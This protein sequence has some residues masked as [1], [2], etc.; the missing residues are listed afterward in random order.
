MSTNHF[1]G[2]KLGPDCPSIHSLLSADDL[3]VCG[4]ATEQEAT[5]MKQILHDKLQIGQNLE[6]FSVSMLTTS[7]LKLFEIFFLCQT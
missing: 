1:A 4:Q 2:I 5:R 3:L 7:P 6:F